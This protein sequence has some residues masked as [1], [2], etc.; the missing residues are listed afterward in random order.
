MFAR[1]ATGL[2]LFVGLSTFALGDGDRAA[3]CASETD[4]AVMRSAGSAG[5]GIPPGPSRLIP[6]L[7]LRA[8]VP[9]GEA[10]LRDRKE[11]PLKFAVTVPE[12]RL[13]GPTDGRLFVIFGPPN[14]DGQPRQRIAETGLDR[15]P[16]LAR[17]VP[18]L[19][20]GAT[21]LVDRDADSFPI[22]GLSGLAPAEYRVQAVFD[23]NPDLRSPNAPGN[24]AS[25]PAVLFVDPGRDDILPITLD[26]VLPEIAPADVGSVKFLK[27]ESKLLS[28]FHGRPIFL[29]AAVI[30]PE[31]FDRDADRKYPLRVHIGGFGSRYFYADRRPPRADDPKFLTLMLDGAGPLGDPYQV[32]SANHG[33][34]GDA[35][36][37]ELIPYVE[38]TYRGIGDGKSRVLD[39][40]STGGWVSLALQVFYPDFFN[41][42]W[43]FCPDA[44]DFRDFQLVNIYRDENAYVN[45]HGFE[46]PACRDRNGDVRYTMRHEVTLENTLGRGGSW[47]LSGGQWGSWNATY[48]PR[49]ADGRPVPLWDPRTGDIDAA[50]AKHWEKYDIRRILEDHWATLG[51]KLRGKIRIWVGE[52]D[53]Y[54]LNNAVH[55]LDTFLKSADPP[56]DASIAFGPGQ[57][58]CWMGISPREMLDQ[59]DRAVGGGR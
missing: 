5:E 17:D 55:R 50:V 21:V 59:M 18:A 26:E 53:D 19:D 22:A 51:P 54:F 57:G 9:A 27:L 13:K 29:R 14:R 15:P 35:I 30:L 56:A 48:S 58:H 40:G 31:G 6:S 25:K 12:G 8:G 34:Y 33:P 38:K 52:A 46:R 32:N 49:G 43:S 4:P 16:I 23:F 39:G 20:S 37:Q 24:L 42:C 2:G 47:A 28:D 1:I 10:T 44:V 3:P 45:A 11:T 41:G 7:A 36:T